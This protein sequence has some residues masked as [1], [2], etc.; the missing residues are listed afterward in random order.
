MF[1]DLFV[2]FQSEVWWADPLFGLDTSAD[3]RYRPATRLR[4]IIS[5]AS[6]FQAGHNSV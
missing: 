5:I 4:H 2:G 6:Q 3:R 1:M